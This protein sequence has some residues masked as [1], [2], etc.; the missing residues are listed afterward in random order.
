[1]NIWLIRRLGLFLI[2]AIGMSILSFSVLRLVPGDP[3]QLLI[4]ERGASPEV[5][6]KLRQNLGLD[7]PILEQYFFFVKNFLSGDLGNSIVSQRPVWQEFIDRFP[8]TLE[9]AFMALFWSL[10]LGLGLGII[11]AYKNGTWLDT[12]TMTLSL[13]GY[14]MP[15]FWWG[16]ILIMI[17]SVKLGLTPVS[18][19]IALAYDPDT[20]T[21]FYLIDTLLSG[22]GFRS[23]FVHLLLPAFVLGTIPL[24]TV[25]RITRASLIEVLGEEYIK[26]LKA[27][28]FSAP[29]ILFVHALRNAFIPILTTIGVLVGSLLTGAILT[30]SLF[31]W[32]GIGRWFVQSVTSRD[33][34]VVQSGILLL[35]LM[36]TFIN[37]VVDSLYGVVNPRLRANG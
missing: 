11:A 13:V 27:R 21:G 1:M 25:S 8:A 22:E 17:F 33:Y 19:R 2:T 4:G 37:L 31:S 34:P 29:Y 10:P 9:L 7:R 35:G 6:A 36:I 32:P 12:S 3:V 14:S 24:A 16:L 18:G 20:I 26:A 30:E 28:G 5:Y 15:I 23:A